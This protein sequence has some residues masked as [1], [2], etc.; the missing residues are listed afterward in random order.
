MF[1]GE[2]YCRPILPTEP[3]LKGPKPTT[4]HAAQQSITTRRATKQSLKL[5]GAGTRSLCRESLRCRMRRRDRC[6]SGKMRPPI[7]GANLFIREP[8]YTCDFTFQAL[9]RWRNIV[10]RFLQGASTRI[11]ILGA[12]SREHKSSY[13]RYP[14][15]IKLPAERIRYVASQLTYGDRLQVNPRTA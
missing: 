2:R 3:V 15:G 11:E 9:S 4:G 8:L 10:A 13:S 14:I 7:F 5:N 1:L 6:V 12:R